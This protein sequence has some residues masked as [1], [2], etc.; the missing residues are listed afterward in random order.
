MAHTFVSQ[1]I[2]GRRIDILNPLLAPEDPVVAA[3][4]TLSEHCT[5]AVLPVAGQPPVPCGESVLRLA[6]TLVHP[7]C[8]N[9]KKIIPLLHTSVPAGGLTLEQM[10]RRLRRIKEISSFP[11]YVVRDVG[12]PGAPR[13]VF[14][15]QRGIAR[16]D[17]YAIVFLLQDIDGVGFPPNAH[18]TFM[19]V[20]PDDVPGPQL[21]VPARP[22]MIFTRL[23]VAVSDMVYW[24]CQPTPE[25]MNAFLQAEARGL[26]CSCCHQLPCLHELDWLAVHSDQDPVRVTLMSNHMIPCCHRG[27][28]LRPSGEEGWTVSAA[29]K[30]GV[31]VVDQSGRRSY[32]SG[33]RDNE[34]I[35]NMGYFL[36][37]LPFVP[38][39]AAE[40][41]YYRMQDRLTW[42][43]NALT[44][45][46]KQY[47]LPSEVVEELVVPPYVLKATYY[48]RVSF[49]AR[50]AKPVKVAVT[51]FTSW[52]VSGITRKVVNNLVARGPSVVTW[53]AGLTGHPF[54][55]RLY[56]PTLVGGLT[57]MAFWKFSQYYYS[58]LQRHFYTRTTTVFPEQQFASTTGLRLTLPRMTELVSRLSVQS[59]VTESDVVDR[60]RRICNEERWPNPIERDEFR[61]WMERLVSEKGTMPYI[62][63]QPKTHCLTCC[64]KKKT[65]RQECRQC[66]MERTTRR[67]PERLLVDSVVL[68]V[69]R[70]G[71]WSRKAMVLEVDMKPDSKLVLG[72]GM[73]RTIQTRAEFKDWYDRQPIQESC[74]GWSSGPIFYGWTPEC[75]P[76]GEATAA[77]AF[78]VRLGTARAHQPREWAWRLV[79]AIMERY[80]VPL[81]PESLD[82]FLSHFRGEKLLKMQEAIVDDQNGDGLKYKEDHKL[83]KALLVK[84]KGFAKA[85]KS[86]SYE[87]VP[88][89]GGWHKERF[90]KR[91]PRFICAPDPVVLLKLGPYTHRQTK[92]LSEAFGPEDHIYYA[93]CSTP[94]Q[95][96][97]WLANVQTA[98]P[99]FGVIVDDISAI[100]SNHNER[101]FQCHRWTRQQQ[102]RAMPRDIQQLFDAIERVVVRIGSVLAFAFNVNASGV[103]DTSYKNSWLCC[104][105]RALA[106]LHAVRDLRT[107]SLLQ[108]LD[109][110][111]FFL[112]V[113]WTSAAGDDGYSAV[114][115]SLFGVRFHSREAMTR[116][117]EFWAWCGFSVKV[118]FVEPHRW[119]MATYLAARP[120]WN[121]TRYSW[122]PEPARRLKSAF[123]QIDNPMHPTVWAKGIA[124][125]LRVIAS[126]QP[127]IRAIADFV[128]NTLDGPTADV[129]TFTNPYSPWA[130][131]VEQ[132]EV[133]QRAVEEFC[134][135]YRVPLSEYSRFLSLVRQI[136]SPFVEFRG[137][138]FERIFSEES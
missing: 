66:K 83:G 22:V 61:A 77:L 131:R 108:T 42:W 105:I 1:A 40:R 122:M 96:D 32:M 116:Y 38:F 11:L 97:Q 5:L 80:I 19:K 13:H 137:I 98:L 17:H 20:T 89:S 28:Y 121:G 60:V 41:A 136:E 138:L 76:R 100:D 55:G 123:W 62:C 134:L 73:G 74:R 127:I 78:F 70:L 21:M 71:I 45:T 47:E 34:A 57:L 15:L 24:R 30:H 117:E 4:P 46:F 69:G 72:R 87:F 8:G 25:N 93:G 130:K 65:Y 35:L 14:I 113:V 43:A 101:S 115:D 109:V 90:H 53:F 44:P 111:S 110:F 23:P 95:M 99:D 112:T 81:E 63:A 2:T 39:T 85:E 129:S 126:C 68:Y 31:S 79:E 3:C 119:R 91:K 107:M 37:F 52:I 132:Y 59:V 10:G 75:F 54:V 120:V 7:D 86:F 84:M 118:S 125:Q 12:A 82:K 94:E 104:I 92:W 33:V 56:H 124:N 16:S 64:Q 67:P 106:L 88:G 18:W 27:T 50:C 36:G 26:A 114:P 58:V 49:L 48:G 133:T 9:E 103:P 29:E 128:Y 6:L 51:A 135:D 102:F